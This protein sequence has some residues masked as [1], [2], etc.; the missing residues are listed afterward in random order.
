MNQRSL[1]II[2]VAVLILLAAPLSFATGNANKEIV[3]ATAHAQMAAVAP[4]TATAVMHFHH[5]INCL[6]GPKG[7]GFDARAGDP[8]KGMGNGALND[9][10]HVSAVHAK[11][12][13][14]LVLSERA[15]HAGNIK[16]ARHDAAGIAQV[17]KAA[18][19]I[20]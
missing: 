17:L 14:A 9:L 2:A 11:L 7:K 10:S 5:V 8:C 12:E 19:S 20:K 1:P 18:S 16:A 15:L 6:V 13:R 4:N 3:T